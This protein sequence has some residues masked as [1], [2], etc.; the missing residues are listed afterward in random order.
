MP[1]NR[2]KI[3]NKPGEGSIIGDTRVRSEYNIRGK[4]SGANN[5]NQIKNLVNRHKSYLQVKMELKT[6][7][8]CPLHQK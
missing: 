6:K 5:D 2:F 8:Y 7:C 3:N 1:E 4:E